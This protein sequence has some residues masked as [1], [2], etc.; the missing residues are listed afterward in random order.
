MGAAPPP[1]SR[2]F[3]RLTAPAILSQ[4]LDAAGL[5]AGGYRMAI[6]RP[7][8]PREYCVQYR[9]SDWAFVTR[10][11]AEEGLHAFFDHEADGGP[12]V[13]ADRSTLSPEIPWGGALPFRPDAGGDHVRRFQVAEEMRPGKVT[14]RGYDYER[15]ARVL[16]SAATGSRDGGIEVYDH[17]SDYVA[18]ARGRRA[19]APRAGAARGHAG[20]LRGRERL[21]APRPRARV[22]ADRSRP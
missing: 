6:S 2:V 13:I 3:Q 8:A 7:F 1:D 14:L 18:A 15:P 11:M 9:E 16:E 17:P 4:V 19:R 20:H 10:L 5:G 22:R 12:L 21:S